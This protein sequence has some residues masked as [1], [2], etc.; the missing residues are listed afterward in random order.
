MI[1]DGGTTV[2]PNGIIM[3]NGTI[4]TPTLTNN[5]V[6]MPTGPNSTPGTL[7]IMETINRVR[8]VR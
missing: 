5:G 7:T 2:G 6:V 1:A 3:G 8:A 4:T